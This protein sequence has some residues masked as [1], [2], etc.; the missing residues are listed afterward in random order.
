MPLPV[1][2]SVASLLPRL[3]AVQYRLISDK[4]MVLDTVM[5]PIKKKSGGI[6]PLFAWITG[7]SKVGTLVSQFRTYSMI[8]NKTCS[9][10][11]SII[12]PQYK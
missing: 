4:I 12:N 10:F 11:R 9:L 8:Y 7:T 1:H 5:E 2:V 3:Y 6:R